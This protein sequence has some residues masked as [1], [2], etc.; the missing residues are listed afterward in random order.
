M[1]CPVPFRVTTNASL[2]TQLNETLWEAFTLG[3]DQ[4]TLNNPLFL[5][6]LYCAAGSAQQCF[7]IC[8][9][10]DLGGVGVRTSFWISSILQA[11]LVAVS[12]EDSTQGA[13]TAA[14]LTASITIPAFIQ[15]KHQALSLYHAT[16]ILN[17]AT[18]SSVVSLAVAPMCTVWRDGPSEEDEFHTLYPALEVDIYG[19]ESPPV[20]SSPDLTNLPKRKVH[21][22]RLILSLALLMQVSLQWTW[23]I[24]LFTDTEYYQA[25][26][27]PDTI[28]L[29]F[30]KAFYT[31]RINH[32]LFIIWP[33]WLLFN[34][35]TTLIWGILLVHSSSP[36]VHP[37][38]S[39]QPSRIDL[40]VTWRDKLPVDKGRIMVLLANL[41]AFLIAVLFLVSSEVQVV[42]NCVLGGEDTD[43]SFG[44]IAA[45]LVALAPA[46]SIFAAL[47]RRHKQKQGR[48]SSTHYDTESNSR[49]DH[50]STSLFTQPDET[51]TPLEE[52]F[53]RSQEMVSI[54]EEPICSYNLGI[55]PF[56]QHIAQNGEP[57]RR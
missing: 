56:H 5:F 41:T 18:F 31:R 32:D 4:S 46:W 43:W 25:A 54:S 33:M 13:W 52:L 40:P 35:A 16:L 48:D 38:L 3:V 22:Q 23:A 44:Q 11:L 19:E 29:L 57:T 47:E 9:N 49:L 17:F 39:R 51:R 30:G 45:L 36:S 27:A 34:L 24:M 42:R 1:S 7:G 8:P 15:K 10:A 37:I 12:P 2:G 6:S 55:P 14:I 28:L 26:C 21:R 50:G 53:D 20:Q